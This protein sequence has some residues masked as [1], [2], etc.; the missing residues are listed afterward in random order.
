M[1]RS[2]SSRSF[3]AKI[4][5]A[6]GEASKTVLTRAVWLFL[7]ARSRG[8]PIGVKAA[9]YTALAYFISPVDAVPDFLPGGYV[10][11]A[12]VLAACVAAAA[13]YIDSDIKTETRQMLRSWGV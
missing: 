10:D 1:A 6:V 9:I 4:G 2:V 3:W 13:A 5:D 12:A 8:T 7:A 11:N